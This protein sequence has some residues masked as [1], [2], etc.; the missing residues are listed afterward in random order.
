MT[1]LSPHHDGSP[2]YV[3]N[4]EPALGA[5]VHVPSKA[6]GEHV[7]HHDNTPR[8]AAAELKAML[9]AG[10]DLV[11]LDSRHVDRVNAEGDL[12]SGTEMALIAD[13]LA[14][15]AGTGRS[16]S[17]AGCGR[18]PVRRR[19]GTD[20][21]R[22]QSVPLTARPQHKQDRVQRSPVRHPRPMTAQRMR[23]PRRQQRQDPLPQPI[24]HPPTIVCDHKTHHL[25]PS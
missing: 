11:V 4:Q 25:P 19:R 18:A 15:S 16:G 13:E 24:R 12:K 3:M 17:D 8:I 14:S 9:D 6:F 1:F 10:K 20:P 23:R 2:L 21:R 5:I 22:V 7:E